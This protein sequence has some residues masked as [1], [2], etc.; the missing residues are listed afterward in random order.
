[1]FLVID[2]DLNI[3]NRD[4]GTC[5]NIVHAHRRHKIAWRIRILLKQIRE[6][7]SDL[8]TMLNRCMDRKLHPVR[9]VESAQVIQS[10]DMI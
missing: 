1:M 3:A 8:I 9:P 10:G 2:V 6:P 7:G 5:L 4:A